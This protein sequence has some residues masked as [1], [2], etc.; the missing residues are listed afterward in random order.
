MKK[1]SKAINVVCITLRLRGNWYLVNLIFNR[2][3]LC[4]FQNISF[5]LIKQKQRATSNLKC[6]K[7]YKLGGDNINL[8]FRGELPYESNLGKVEFAAVFICLLL[9]PCKQCQRKENSQFDGLYFQQ[10]LVLICQIFRNDKCFSKYLTHSKLK[11]SA[12]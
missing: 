8:I 3:Q 7:R 2:A 11:I 6:L 1:K 5:F 10:Q 12:A 4:Y 9:N